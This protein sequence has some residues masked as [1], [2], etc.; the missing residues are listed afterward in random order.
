[1]P[2]VISNCE[3]YSFQYNGIEF[4]GH[5]HYVHPI[6]IHDDFIYS[7]SYDRTIKKW[8]LDGECV[9]TFEGHTKGINSVL[10]HDDFLYSC[11]GDKTI[12]K[13]T[14]DGEHIETIPNSYLIE[15]EKTQKIVALVNKLRLVLV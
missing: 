6:L 7:S 15:C 11:S 1:M 3:S 4:E 10:I 8:T 5:T 9:A 13:W 12:R 2:L 14:L